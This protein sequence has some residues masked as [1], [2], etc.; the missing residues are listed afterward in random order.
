MLNLYIR[1]IVNI[2]DKVDC[3]TEASPW[4]LLSNI[5]IVG[6]CTYYR[7]FLRFASALYWVLL[8]LL[9]QSGSCRFLSLVPK[10]HLSLT[11]CFNLAE[12]FMRSLKFVNKVSHLHVLN[13][14]D[15]GFF[16]SHD[17]EAK[18]WRAQWNACFGNVARKYWCW[19]LR[20][21]FWG[22]KKNSSVHL[23][24]CFI[25]RSFNE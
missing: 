21:L 16:D 6:A 5:V 20:F 19:K 17:A 11:R 23:T 9:C 3:L 4:V 15:W 8:L 2:I 22:S 25:T 18:V 13:T 14:F 1:I 24:Y 7:C 12:E 10:M